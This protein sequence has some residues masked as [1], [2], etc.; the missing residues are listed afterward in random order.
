MASQLFNLFN[1]MPQAQGPVGDFQN[2]LTQFNQFRS[3][4]RGDARQQVQ[5]M[6]NSGQVSNEQ[7]NQLSQVATQLYNQI[8]GR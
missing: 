2:F 4:F 3:A 5:Q 8:H 7:V 6:I 1:N